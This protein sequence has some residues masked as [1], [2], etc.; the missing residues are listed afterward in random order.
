[1]NNKPPYCKWVGVLLGLTLNGSAHFVAG[2]RAVGLKWYF[3]L[4]AC[5]LAC[6]A[7][8]VVPGTFPFTL[9]MVFGVAG[10]VLWFVMLIQ[11]YQPVR[12]I[13][14]IG[15]L[16]VIFLSVV[17]N[18][19][20]R[21]LILQFVH[22]FKVPTGAMQPTIYGIHGHYVP[23]NSKDK[24]GLIQWLVFGDWYLE[25]KAQSSGVLSKPQLSRDAS[26]FYMTY[27]V[28]SR[29]YDLP[30]CVSPLKQPGEHVS[31]GE[32]LWSGVITTGDHLFVERLSYR[33]GKPKRGDIVV[34]RTDGIRNLR[35]GTLYVKRI[36]GLP[37]ERVRIEP[38]FLI[39]N[40]QKV[41][42]PE[43]FNTISRETNGYAGFQLASVTNSLLS[44]PSDEVTLGP[45]EYFLLGDNT[46][47]SLDSRYW[48]AVPE[49]N[50][51]GRVTRIYWPFMR[52]NAL[53]GKGR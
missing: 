29:S 24:P 3:G 46:Q 12:R 45:T 28:D 53:E 7:F 14:I 1:M 32:T 33:C 25:V 26:F 52:I 38:P 22:P 42:E 43:I 49:K 5:G 9:G 51:Y 36:A 50:I 8:L 10:V 19:G 40:D 21:F 15:W 41:V 35:S 13:G 47:N 30:R 6:M 31:S 16:V 2:K 48:G 18:E 4:V 39:V 27:M 34:F 20:W 44:K 37:G 11:S 23:A 17:L